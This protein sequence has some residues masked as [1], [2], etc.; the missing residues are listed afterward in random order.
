MRAR[1]T[2][3]GAFEFAFRSAVNNVREHWV[4]QVQ[5]GTTTPWPTLRVPGGWYYPA[6]PMN[7]PELSVMDPPP[8]PPRPFS[9]VVAYM[10]GDANA[11]FWSGV[12]PGGEFSPPVGTPPG[13]G[14]NER[15]PTAVLSTSAQAI[16]MVWNVGPMA[17]EGTA[18]VLWGV[19]DVNG[20]FLGKSGNLGKCFAGTKATAWVD[21]LG[22]F[23]VMTTAN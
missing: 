20:T 15:Y 19:W 5:G 18:E 9:A 4:V 11:V 23:Y 7:G 12:G 3:V 16:L 2:G 13:G 21:A 22:E 17:T 1:S 14:S 8:S 10:E 6:C